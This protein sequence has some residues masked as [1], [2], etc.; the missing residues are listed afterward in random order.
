MQQLAARHG[1]QCISVIYRGNRISLRWRCACDHEW[2]AAAISVQRGKWC[3]ICPREARSHAWLAQMQALAAQRGGRCLS[4]RYINSRTKLRW[5]CAQRHTW[6]ATPAATRIAGA[7]CPV[8]AHNKHR[9][10]IDHM[11]ALAASHG[12]Q[13]LSSEYTRSTGKL[14]WRCAEGHEW[15][16]SAARVRNGFWCAIC[17]RHQRRSSKLEDMHTL[18][19][20]HGGRCL[21][22]AYTSNRDSLRWRCRQGH[23]WSATPSSIRR[24]TWCPICA[25]A[26]RS[27]HTI[28]EM[29]EIA[30]ERGGLCLS[31]SYVNLTTKLE[32][33][34]ARGHAW[35]T[36]PAVVLAGGWCPACKYMG[37]CIT[38]EARRKYLV[39]D[40]P[41]QT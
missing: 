15:I 36:S 21:S 34:C 27:N 37:Q 12:G 41:T 18:A 19:A 25:Q 13:C 32:W 26:D 29:R 22:R 35:R 16:T 8:C 23:T 28:E 1:G 14:R 2:E 6:D 40:L 9:Q 3:P 10:T 38:E 17:A 30:R 20:G 31:G 39:T 11:Q 7:W 5:Q 24:G 4:T 33:Q